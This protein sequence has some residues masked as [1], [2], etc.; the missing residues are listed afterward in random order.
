M[1]YRLP[2]GSGNA[3][4]GRRVSAAFM[5]HRMPRN[6]RGPLV[7]ADIA[8]AAKPAHNVVEFSVSEL[9]NAIKQALEDGFG[10]VRLRGEISGFRGPTP[11]A[12]ATSP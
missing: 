9:S 4:S 11:R 2:Q 12:I 1:R 8:R 7:A 5:Y 3:A 10:F 6:K